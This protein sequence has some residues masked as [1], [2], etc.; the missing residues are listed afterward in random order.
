VSPNEAVVAGSPEF[1]DAMLPLFTERLGGVP[2]VADSPNLASALC[3]DGARLLVYEHGGREWL[4]LCTDLRGVTGPDL[5]VIVALPPEHASDVAVIS[6]TASAV[7]AWRG[8]AQP[9]LEAANRVLAARDAPPPPPRRTG[10]VLTPQPAKIALR[11]APTPPRPAAATPPPRPVMTPAPRP[12]APRADLSDSIFDEEA[13]ADAARPEVA[14]ADSP[15]PPSIQAAP[16]SIPAPFAV[17]PGT[18]LSAADGQAVMRAALSGLWPEPRL[19]PVTEKLV[20]SLST[21]EKGATLGQKLPFDPVP[22]RRA[23]GL[24]WQVAAALDTLP[25]QGAKVDQ[26]AV[27]VILG[28]IDEV[29]ADLKT[30]SDDAS[31][32]ALR[33][34]ETIRHALV[35]EAIDLTEALQ[36]VAP[37]EM[38][39]EITTSRK[40][41][42][43]AAPVTRMVYTAATGPDRGPRQVPWG[44]VVVLVVAVA[45][46]VGYHGYRY[47]NR[48]AQAASMISGAPSGT[49]GSVTPQGKILVTPAGVK[50]DPKEVENF[51]NLEKAKGN[52]V[53]EI[54]PGTF[55]VSP[56]TA[57]PKAAGGSGGAS[58]Q[59]ARP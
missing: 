13:V 27:Q 38:V 1:V 20:A 23:V 24:R 11:P 21:A 43:A 40:A 30:L 58:T 49:V 55:I 28:G 44:L 26:S 50:L 41:R 54:S 57:R 52:D 6:A 22:V 19:R 36:H 18:V 25:P 16:P 46:A 32:D 35:K 37:P 10:P 56:E 47:V 59:G 45:G 5:A 3:Q 4:T 9:V 15:P 17:W 8:Q 31:P 39:K 12:A 33:A 2:R 34:L 53:R 29:L 7:V 51:K 42:K 14:G 48:P